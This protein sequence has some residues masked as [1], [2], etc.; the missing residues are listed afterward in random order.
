M[1][2]NVYKIIHVKRKNFNIESDLDKIYEKVHMMQNNKKD[3]IS[4]IYGF[5][6][7]NLNDKAVQHIVSD[8]GKELNADNLALYKDRDALYGIQH[9]DEEDPNESV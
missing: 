1:N 8:V 3:Y 4:G 7:K 2:P 9:F 6:L 5:K